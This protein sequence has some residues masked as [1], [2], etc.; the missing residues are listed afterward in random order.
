M[1]ITRVEAIP[2]WASFAD[3]LGGPDKVPADLSSPAFGMTA[4]PLSGQGCAIVRVHTDEGLVGI[5]ESMGRPGARG[6]AALIEEV[7]APLLVGQDPLRVEAHWSAMSRQLRFA[8]TAVSGVD[9]ALWDL[10]GKAYGEP[11]HR[12]L[13]GPLRTEIECYA[14]PV[15]FLPSPEE[16][17]ARALAFIDDGFRA[18]KL[19]IGRGVDVDLEHVAAVRDALGPGTPLMIDAN[20]AYGLSDSVR[21]ARGLLR[22]DVFWLEEPISLEHPAE[23]AE[24]R[25]KV[26]LP[27]ATGE[28]LASIYQYRDLLDAGGADVLMPNVARCGGITAMRRIAEAAALRKVTIAPHGVGSGVG[29][30]A[31]LQAIAATE[32]FL[33]YEYNQLFNPLRHAVLAEPIVFRDG[34]LHVPTTPGIGVTLDDD[35]IDR[36]D[37]RR[38]GAELAG[39]PA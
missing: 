15:P 35:A 3:A 39:A 24:L 18:I 8:P 34:Q 14:S 38:F 13:G 17:A 4:V 2:L 33:V 36:F 9:I 20:G 27:I 23:L 29:I 30:L 12:L 1:R 11:V 16:S 10:R 21:L 5:G 28:G 7:L 26:E 22:H 6:I 32:N 37:A 31:A 19:K 25:R